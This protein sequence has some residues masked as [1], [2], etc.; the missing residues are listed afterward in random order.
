MVGVQATAARLS[1]ESVA[2]R[3]MIEKLGVGQILI[4]ISHCRTH[5]T[6]YALAL[7]PADDFKQT[8]HSDDEE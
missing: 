5:A 4:S 7:A 8:P 6:A 3:D 1:Q 2:A